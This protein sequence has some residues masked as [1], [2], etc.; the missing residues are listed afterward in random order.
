MTSKRKAELQRKLSMT[1]VPKP[2]AGLSERLKADIPQN[3]MS[4]DRDRE[5]FRRS[6]IFSMRVAASILLLVT[7]AYLALHFVSQNESAPKIAS[8]PPAMITRRAAAPAAPQA[9]V[10]ITLAENDKDINSG[11]VAEVAPAVQGKARVEE[12]KEKLERR[13]RVQASQRVALNETRSLTTDTVAAA[14]ALAAP[15]AVAVAPPP[16]PPAPAPAPSPA[17]AAA[18]V[19]A[20]ASV[21]RAAAKTSASEAI[22]VTAQAPEIISTAHAA[23]L[24]FEPPRAVFGLSID[25][26]VFARVKQEIEHGERPVTDPGDVSALINYFAGPARAKRH[27][28]NLDVEASR[29]PL[30]TDNSALLR[31]TIDTPHETIPTGGSVPPAATDA[32]LEITLNSE[33]VLSHRLIG[34]D[35]LKAQST[36]LKNVSV[37]GLMDLKLKPAI[38]PRT[39]IATLRLSYRSVVDGKRRTIIRDVRAA[40]VERTWASASRRHRLPTLSAAWSE[41]LT[42]KTANACDVARTAEK[43]ATEAPNDARAKELAALA[44]ASCR[45]QSSAPTGSAR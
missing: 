40:D 18:P 42:E 41:S 7:S 21:A 34:A 19:A 31:F 30:T 15:P 2:P 44:S 23:A 14:P 43:L 28:V 29:A 12:R 13:E 3:L 39:N 26:N 33:V 27:D 38:A 37:T 4:V 32:N 8:T 6:T 25:P 35:E 9:E 16:P 5:R 1:S 20:D 45:L 36:L 22:N 17:P 24:S 11:R 10:T